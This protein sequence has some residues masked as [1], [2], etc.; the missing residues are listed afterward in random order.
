M[1]ECAARGAEHRIEPNAS[2]AGLVHDLACRRHVAEPAK[3][4]VAGCGMDDVRPAALRSEPLRQPLKRRV[5]RR[6]VFAPREGVQ[7]RAEHPVEEQVARGAVEI[8]VP[9]HAFFELDVHLHP[10]SARARGGE[11]GQVRLHRAG[12]QHGVRAARLR[13]AEIKLQLAHLVAPE[14]EPRAVVALDPE[15][16]PEGG[17]E[18][19]GVLERCRRVAEPDPREAGDPGQGAGHFTQRLACRQFPSQCHSFPSSVRFLT[20]PCNPTGPGKVPNDTGRPG[21]SPELQAPHQGLLTFQDT[22]FPHGL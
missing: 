5:R 14:G 9:L 20:R 13:R 17:A 12:D 21:R 16:H 3:R 7:R 10:E 2:G 18:I 8:A 15:F 22:R 6:L 4:R 11:A 1:G 19:G